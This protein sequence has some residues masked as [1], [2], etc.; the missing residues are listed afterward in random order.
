MSYLGIDIG[1]TYIKYAVFNNEGVQLSATERQK[2]K[3][4]ESTNYILDQVCQICTTTQEK[5]RLQGVAISTAGVVDSQKG[6]I[7]Y[8]GYTIPGYTGTP[9]KETVETLTKVKCTVINDVNA[10]CLGEYWQAFTE[11]EKPKTLVCLTIGT[12]VGGA[13][14]IDGKLYEGPSFMAGEVGYLPIEGQYFQDIA[15]TT[16]LLVDAKRQLNEEITGEEFF[17]RLRL[18]SDE[19]V[20][21]VFER[22]IS[23]LAKGVLIMQYTL[24]PDQIVLGGGIL[25]Q[26]DM[27]I[28]AIEQKLKELA[29]SERFLTAKIS[30]ARAGN[31]A[32]MLG[33]LYFHLY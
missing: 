8:A 19:R 2:T 30:P 27:I 9:L 1:G 21:Q 5:Y 22:F 20:N 24:N 12:G 11:L 31:N 16:A 3:I 15:S 10:A 33:A 23:A 13:I 4:T 26:H 25:A 18:A 17:E 29:V 32:G 14:I 28:P 7:T 6:V